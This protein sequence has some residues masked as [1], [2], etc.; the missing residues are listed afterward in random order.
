MNISGPKEEVNGI[1]SSHTDD[2]KSLVNK[3][4]QRL[5]GLDM[6]YRTLSSHVANI[7]TRLTTLDSRI[8]RF[9]DKLETILKLLQKS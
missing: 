9:E 4:E 5:N 3:Y 8:V 6:S 2:F 7:D 1:Q